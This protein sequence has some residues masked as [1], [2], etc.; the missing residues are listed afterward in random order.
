MEDNL[1][2]APHIGELLKQFT[3]EKRTYK[4]AWARI[5]KV[6]RSTILRY[7]R[8]PS[9]QIATLFTISQVLKYNFFRQIADTLPSE[10]PPGGNSQVEID[11]LKKQVEDLKKENAILRD[12]LKKN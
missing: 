8:K 2:K 9:M 1:I 7:L 10:F 6:E 11:A 5:Q 3:T 12:L 4:G